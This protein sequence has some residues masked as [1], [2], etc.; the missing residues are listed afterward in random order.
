MID[1]ALFIQAA[2]WLTVLTFFVCSSRASI[3]HPITFYLVFHGLVF[4]V[5]PLFVRY[6][7]FDA[8][9]NYMKFD[10]TDD[11]FVKTLAISSVGLLMFVGGCWFGSRNSKTLAFSGSE[12]KFTPSESLSLYVLWIMFLPI[13]VYSFI[14]TAGGIKGQWEG[15]VFV[16]TGASG[17]VYESQNII[18]PLLALLLLRTRFN[19]F[20]LIVVIAYYGYRAL[21]G[22]GRWTI[23]LSGICYVLLY[24]WAHR[25]TRLP[26]FVFLIIPVVYLVFAILGTGR[27]LIQTISPTEIAKSALL[28]KT[29]TWREKYDTFDFANFDFLAYIAAVVPK[30]TKTYNYGIDYLQLVTEPIP[31]AIWKHKPIGAPSLFDLN[32]YGNFRGLTYSLPGNGWM[33]GGWWGVVITCCLWGFGLGRLYKWFSWRERSKA[34]ALLYIMAI[35]MIVQLYRDGNVSIFRFWLFTIPPIV[36]W[37]MLANAI[38]KQWWYRQSQIKAADLSIQ[39]E[40][41]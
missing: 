14:T 35:S 11:D 20:S 23:V 18:I 28:D 4:V 24:C 31:R 39:Q 13:I 9:W 33:D 40:R 8:A 16:M 17:Y 30:E 25:R 5:R 15:G 32:D 1:I 3:F 26:T 6:A 29:L 10:P 37:K 36:I 12:I 19:I 34:V 38:D 21:V 41:A 22:W 7:D 27:E 2:I